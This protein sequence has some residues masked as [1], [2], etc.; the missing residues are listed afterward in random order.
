MYYRQ[1]PQENRRNKWINVGV[2]IG[3][4]IIVTLFVR[5][6]PPQPKVR[7]EHAPGGTPYFVFP[8]PKPN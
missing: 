2:F 7:I 3:L 1:T 5:A 6:C 4:P 8:T